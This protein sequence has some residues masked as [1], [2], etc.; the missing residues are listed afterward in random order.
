MAIERIPTI[1]GLPGFCSNFPDVFLDIL[2]TSRPQRT[3][4]ALG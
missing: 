1:S 2:E 4:G 3:K